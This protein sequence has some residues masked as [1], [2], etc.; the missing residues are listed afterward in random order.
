MRKVK[1]FKSVETELES[2]ERSINEWVMT[3]GAKIISVTGNIAPQ[4]PGAGSGLNTFA[5]SD[6]LVVVLYEQ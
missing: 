3:S 4:S 1:L 2:L 5:A 6:L